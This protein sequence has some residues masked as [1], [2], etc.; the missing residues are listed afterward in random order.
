MFN[1]EDYEDVASLNRWFQENYPMGRIDLKEL[2]HDR[3]KGL[4]T[5]QAYIYRDSSDANPATT[6]IA[7]G[8]R[9]LYNAS[10]KKFYAED[11]ATSSIGR[12]IILLKGAAKTATRESMQ[13]VKVNDSKPLPKPFTEKLADK[14]IMPVEDDPWTVKAV[15]PAGTIT[16]AL[17]LMTEVMGATKIDKD[18]PQCLHGAREWRTGNKNGRA[19][20]NMGC[21]AKPMNGERWSEVNKCEPIWYVI[22]NNGAWKPQEVKS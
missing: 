20:A 11:V 21:S 9:D 2:F 14:I 10:L 4:V 5:Y 19:W 16:D 17:A 12:A 13:Q 18:I 1:L 6:N 22:D 3:E 15:E 7:N 8:S